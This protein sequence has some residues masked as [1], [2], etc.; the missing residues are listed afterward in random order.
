MQST[1]LRDLTV[2][3]ELTLEEEYAMQ[4]ELSLISSTLAIRTKPCVEEEAGRKTR[5]VH[6]LSQ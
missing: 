2:S 5:T 3:K 1:E 6:G 4:R